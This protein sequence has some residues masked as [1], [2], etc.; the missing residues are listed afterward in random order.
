[1]WIRQQIFTGK[2][3][4]LWFQILVC[5]TKRITWFGPIIF[6]LIHCC[7]IINIIWK[8]LGYFA[9]P[10]FTKTLPESCKL[11]RPCRKEK[12]DR[13]KQEDRHHP[14]SVYIM[15]LSEVLK[16]TSICI[17]E[18]KYRVLRKLQKDVM[19]FKIKF[20]KWILSNSILIE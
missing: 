14:I 19:V 2:A 10:P 3:S 8:K 17:K 12:E 11:S 6:S 9:Y 13:C 16:S 5:M 7:S 1:V 20:P 15:E 18:C 4:W